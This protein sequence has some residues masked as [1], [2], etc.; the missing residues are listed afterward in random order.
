VSDWSI[1]ISC[2]GEPAQSWACVAMADD[3]DVFRCALSLLCDLQSQYENPR[4]FVNGRSFVPTDEQVADYEAYLQA[5]VA[6]ENP[7]KPPLPATCMRAYVVDTAEH[8]RELQ[9]R[10]DRKHTQL[11]TPAVSQPPGCGAKV[12]IKVKVKVP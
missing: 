11:K 4:V 5:V 7:P 9:E 1:T 6:H 8:A 3:T 10:E 12:K 2:A